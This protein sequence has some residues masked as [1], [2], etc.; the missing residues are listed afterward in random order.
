MTDGTGDDAIVGSLFGSLRKTDTHVID[1]L[2]RKVGRR[3]KSSR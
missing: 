1:L 3:D 2:M